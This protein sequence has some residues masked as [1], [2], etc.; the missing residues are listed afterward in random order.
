M[1]GLKLEQSDFGCAKVYGI[2]LKGK[3]QQSMANYLFMNITLI[4]C[5]SKGEKLEKNFIH[6]SAS[7]LKFL[8]LHSTFMKL[9]YLDLDLIL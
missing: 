8:T 3:L 9:L 2:K 1:T 4:W 7:A 6:G 5:H